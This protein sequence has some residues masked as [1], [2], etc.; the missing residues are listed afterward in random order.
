MILPTKKTMYRRKA[1]FTLVESLVAIVVIALVLPVVLQALSIATRVSSDARNR[2]QAAQLAKAKLDE[3]VVTA[4]WKTQQLS[5]DFQEV[6]PGFTWSAV[7]YGWGTG[8]LNQL[9]VTVTYPGVGANRRVT[10]STLVSQEM[11]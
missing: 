4:D 9:D 1:G 3:L 7:I 6:N 10:V 5:G 11:K 8:S 2:A